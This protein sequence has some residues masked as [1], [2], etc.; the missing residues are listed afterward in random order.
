[1][2]TIYFCVSYHRYRQNLLIGLP[3]KLAEE[4]CI[5][6]DLKSLG[7]EVA[8]LE[9]I[10]RPGDGDVDF[11]RRYLKTQEKERIAMKLRAARIASLQVGTSVSTPYGSAVVSLQ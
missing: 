9:S 6:D 5:S 10:L 11:S 7:P 3:S 4:I 8:A 2:F 1:M